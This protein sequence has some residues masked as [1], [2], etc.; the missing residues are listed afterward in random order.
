MSYSPL[1]IKAMNENA[2]D[3]VVQR[4]LRQRGDL[5][6]KLLSE[7]YDLSEKTEELARKVLEDSGYKF[8]QK[9]P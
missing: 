9:G 1:A 2:T 8:H 7:E 4:A 6:A 3:A 5:A